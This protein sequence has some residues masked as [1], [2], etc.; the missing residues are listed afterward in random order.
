MTDGGDSLAR[1]SVLESRLLTLAGAGEWEALATSLEA[2]DALL[3]GLDDADRAQ[4]L[5]GAQRCTRELE[6]LARAARAECAREIAALRSGARA[7]V[8]YVTVQKSFT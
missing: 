3:A 5:A 8:S 2:R 6:R 7:T 4:A 1:L